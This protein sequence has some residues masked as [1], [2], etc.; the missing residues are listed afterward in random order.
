MSDL[1]E[2]SGCFWNRSSLT[3]TAFLSWTL[4]FCLNVYPQK[5]KLYSVSVEFIQ[6]CTSAYDLKVLAGILKDNPALKAELFRYIPDINPLNPKRDN[7]VSSNFA[8]RMHP[9]DKQMKMHHGIDIAAPAGTPVHVAANGRVTRA[10]QSDSGYGNQVVVEHEFGFS[11]VY[12]HLYTFIVKE[13]MMLTKGDIIGFVGS[14]GKSTGNHI[15]YE[16]RKE[17]KP[18]DPLPFIHLKNL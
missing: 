13:G 9:L 15:H 4:F 6:R 17:G 5:D 12:A 10:S 11:T 18:I 1:Q 8:V 7:P 2:P 16:I 14:T 3:K